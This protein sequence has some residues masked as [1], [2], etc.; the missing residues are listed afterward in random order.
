MTALYAMPANGTQ[1]QSAI[2]ERVVRPARN[3]MTRTAAKSL[4]RFKF[5][6]ADQRRMSR[7]LA[8]A[9][10]GNLTP[11]QAAELENYRNVGRMIDLVQSEARQM[12]SAGR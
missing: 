2:L 12:L 3:G 5:S 1:S 11:N 9:Q 10:A 4:L 6:A 7:L 8:A